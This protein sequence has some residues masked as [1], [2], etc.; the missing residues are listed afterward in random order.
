MFKEKFKIKKNLKMTIDTSN[1]PLGEIKSSEKKKLLPESRKN[2]EKNSKYEMECLI[3]ASPQTWKLLFTLLFT[4]LLLI[5]LI[6][7][8][9]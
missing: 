7:F 4:L 1:I 2:N 8:F 9:G 3:K 5:I 6:A